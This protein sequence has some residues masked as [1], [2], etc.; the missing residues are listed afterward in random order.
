MGFHHIYIYDNN[1]INGEKFE[2]VIS[3]EIK[4]GFVSIINYRGYKAIQVEA[5]YD[6]YK[7]NYKKFKW[8]AFFDFDE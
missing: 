5:Y 6:C 4:N 7:N 8:L 2:E 1:E 3:E